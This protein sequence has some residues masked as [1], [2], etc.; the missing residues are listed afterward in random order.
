MRILGVTAS[1]FVEP[2]TYGL[3]ASTILTA[4]E[5]SVTFGNLDQY[6]STF[7]HLQVRISSRNLRS[8]SNE[9]L[10]MRFNNDSGQNY[11]THTLL[12][13]GSQ[14][15][16]I[17][18]PNQTYITPGIS[19][20]NTSTANS[21][22]SSIVDILDAFSPSKNKTTRSLSLW[23]N[24]NQIRLDSSAWNNTAPISSISIQGS[25]SNFMAGSRFSL[26]GIRG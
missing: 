16:S 21:F 10:F 6:S 8:D 15:Q 3:V 20:G 23:G 11:F 12:S 26:Y 4:N 7:T 22:G 1:G 2:V 18:G 13:N 9:T 5:P 17:P 25:I 19:N 24:P 14:I